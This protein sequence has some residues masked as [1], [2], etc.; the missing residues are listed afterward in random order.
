MYV[1][2]QGHE[3]LGPGTSLVQRINWTTGQ[4]AE[5]AGLG[6]A[7][8]GKCKGMGL[9][10]GGPDTWGGLEWGAVAVGGYMV[11]SSILTTRRGV[12]AVRG[13]VGGAYRGAKSGARSSS[14]KTSKTKK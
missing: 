3:H 4:E 5:L 14:S 8:G 7:C 13:A 12:R 2:G 1:A 9:F 10:D 6:C 11:L